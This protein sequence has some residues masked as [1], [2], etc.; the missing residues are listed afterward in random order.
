MT[1]LRTLRASALALCL[2][3]PAASAADPTVG[4]AMP[5]FRVDDLAGAHRT[6]RDLAGQWTVALVMTDKDVG[7]ELTAWWRRLET[8][9]PPPARVYTFVAI[10]L[11]PLVPTSTVLSQARDATPRARWNTVWFS[12]DGSFAR[13]LGLPEDETPWVLVTDPTGRVALSL[14]AR[15]SDAGVQRVLATLGAAP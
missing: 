3:L 9:V 11:F 13:S 8:A 6:E 7:P 2:A 1:D 14:H 5:A 10:N 12:R 4:A 15:A